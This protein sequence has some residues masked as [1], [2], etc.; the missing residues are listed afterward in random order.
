MDDFLAKIEDVAIQNK[1]MQLIVDISNTLLQKKNQGVKKNIE[2]IRDYYLVKLDKIAY[3]SGLELTLEERDMRPVML[4]QGFSPQ[5]VDTFFTA[6]LTRQ[7]PRHDDF[8]TNFKA[9]AESKNRL[10]I[11]YFISCLNK[12]E[13]CL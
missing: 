9:L 8:I 5:L 7:F 13:Q 1:T 10:M 4:A 6:F 2:A 3:M 12:A 11:S